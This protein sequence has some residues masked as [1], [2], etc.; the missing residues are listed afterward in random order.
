MQNN[1]QRW[2]VES[3]GVICFVWVNKKIV[4]GTA[5][6]V[7]ICSTNIGPISWLDGKLDSNSFPLKFGLIAFCT[8][9]YYH[10]SAPY[11]VIHIYIYLFT[12]VQ[13]YM[14]NIIIHFQVYIFIFIFIYV[15]NQH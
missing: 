9:R 2:Y 10:F 11:F 15:S 8:L 1:L 13:I 7:V 5:A 12:L 6:V 4:C 3:F 14:K